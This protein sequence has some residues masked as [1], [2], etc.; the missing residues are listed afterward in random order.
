MAFEVERPLGST[1]EGPV[2][3]AIKMTLAGYEARYRISAD[4]HIGP[5]AIGFL[6]ASRVTRERAV[7]VA[8][9]VRPK[10][11]GAI[12]NLYRR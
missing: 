9:S 12:K 11:W 7:A 8:T 10:T 2:D 6:N 5:H 3:F 1:Y 4:V